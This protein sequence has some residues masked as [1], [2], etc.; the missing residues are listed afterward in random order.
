MRRN[1]QYSFFLCIANGIPA[2]QDAFEW[3]EPAR[4]HR[5]KGAAGK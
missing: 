3:N 4:S 1:Q 2:L 5:P